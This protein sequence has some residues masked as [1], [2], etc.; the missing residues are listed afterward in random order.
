MTQLASQIQKKGTEFGNVKVYCH[1]IH[2]LRW[3]KNN[4][5]FLLYIVIVIKGIYT[6]LN[7]PVYVNYYDSRETI[8]DNCLTNSRPS[9]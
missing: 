6:L 9:D 8:L 2:L 3:S 5:T 4:Q 1:N 7:F